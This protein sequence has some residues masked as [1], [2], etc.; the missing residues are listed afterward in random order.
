MTSSCFSSDAKPVLNSV[1]GQFG[2]GLAE[3][4]SALY[5]ALHAI[6][7]LRARS[8]PH[9][10]TRVAGLVQRPGAA[11]LGDQHVALGLR[12][13]QLLLQLPQCRLEVFHLG[14]LV[15]HLVPKVRRQ[16]SIAEGS[17]NRGSRQIV[18]LLVHRQFG[19]ANPVGGFLLVLLLL[20]FEQM[21]VGDRDRHLGLHLQQ[22]ILHIENHLLDHLLGLLGL[23]DDV[24][25]IGPHQRS[26]AL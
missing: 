26:H 6:K 18:L 8:V 7:R 25:E 16:G 3:R 21:L 2:L 1:S 15:G 11:M 10:H 12:L 24:V 19:L 9:R 4:F 13:G 14:G 22:L 23:V 5:L 20:L 17:L